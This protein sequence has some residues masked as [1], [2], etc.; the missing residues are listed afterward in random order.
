MQCISPVIIIANA[1][2]M[3]YARCAGKCGRP[4]RLPLEST[5]CVYWWNY[6]PLFARSGSRAWRENKI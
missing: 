3:N 4:H 2:K 5:A 6:I 1:N